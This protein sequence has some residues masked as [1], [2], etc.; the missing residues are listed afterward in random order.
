VPRERSILL[1]REGLLKGTEQCEE[2]ICREM[3]EVVIRNP[4]CSSMVG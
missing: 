3:D 4:L 1:I 2:L